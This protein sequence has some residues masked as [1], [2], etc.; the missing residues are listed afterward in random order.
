VL[1]D[2]TAAIAAGS[3]LHEVSRWAPAHKLRL[4]GNTHPLIQ[5]FDDAEFRET[6]M[7]PTRIIT[8]EVTETTND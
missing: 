1:L 3:A 6:A 5:S 7:V 4:F 2:S 8:S